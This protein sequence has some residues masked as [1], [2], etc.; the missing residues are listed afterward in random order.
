MMRS[1]QDPVDRAV[2]SLNKE[3]GRTLRREPVERD[4][5]EKPTPQPLQMD[6]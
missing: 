3:V 4:P 2:S 6:L 5:N 1:G